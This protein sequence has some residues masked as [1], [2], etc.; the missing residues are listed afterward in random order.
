MPCQLRSLFV[1]MLIV[2]STLLFTQQPASGQ[3]AMSPIWKNGLGFS[4]ADGKNKIY[5]GGRLQIDTGFF[6]EE[7]GVDAEEDG[8]RMRRARI[9]LSGLINGNIEFKTQYDFSGGD[10]DFKDFYMGFLNKGSM[11]SVI[12]KIRVGQQYEPFGLETLTSSKYI[13]LADLANHSPREQAGHTHRD[14][15]QNH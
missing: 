14:H 8:V 5:L 9:A 6:S 2:T 10:A 3:D 15:L 4:T 1:F 12:S 7:D 11:P 13:T